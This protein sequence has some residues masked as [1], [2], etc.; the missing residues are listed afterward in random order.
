M[1]TPFPLPGPRLLLVDGNHNVRA[2]LLGLLRQEY[3]GYR[4]DTVANPAQAS[5]LAA[6]TVPVLGVVNIDAPEGQ[7][8]AALRSLRGL[9]P[10]IRLVAVSLHPVERFREPATLAGA[11]QCVCIALADD[12]LSRLL[13]ALKPQAWT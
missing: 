5:L 7:G 13:R 9:L 8:F 3:P 12:G 6:G 2:A 10:D 11:T 1:D 4:V